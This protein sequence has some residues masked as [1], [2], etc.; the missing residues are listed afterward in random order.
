MSRSRDQNLPT[1]AT[2]RGRPFF[3]SLGTKKGQGG[4]GP[5]QGGLSDE[6]GED[7]A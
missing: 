1:R 3:S 4:A 2:F 5:V 7:T 6:Q